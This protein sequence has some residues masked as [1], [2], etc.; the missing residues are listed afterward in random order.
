MT[1]ASG[2]E[3]D[4]D[5]ERFAV[6]DRIRRTV[7]SLAAGRT[8]VLVLEDL[9]W[10]DASSLRVLRHLCA[11][12]ATGRLLVLCTWRRGAQAGALTETAEALAR[13]HAT[14]LDLTGLSRPRRTASWRRS[15]V[16]GWTTSSRGRCT[17]GPRA[18]RSSWSSTPDSPVTST[19]TWPQRWRGCPA[20]WPTSC[21]DG[22]ARSRRTPLPRSPPVP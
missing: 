3:G 6:S 5:A 7:E 15:R 8:V 20:R 14:R 16:T 18:T 2:T 9:H 1:E 11:H 17:T 10:A 13:R 19:T 22:S 21:A 12:T 4:H